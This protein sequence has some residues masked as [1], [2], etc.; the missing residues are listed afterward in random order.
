M[1]QL[2]LPIL[3]LLASQLPAQQLPEPC[4]PGDCYCLY[5]SA[6]KVWK[7][8]QYELAVNKLNAWK[9]CDTERLAEAYELVIKVIR[10]EEGLKK[11]SYD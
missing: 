4:Y 1:K 8:G 3:L 7:A 6:M 5:E 9:T 11:A 10:E 2:I